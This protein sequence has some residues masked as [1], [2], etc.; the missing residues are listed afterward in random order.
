[1]NHKFTVVIPTR[2]RASTLRS[3]IESVIAQ[4]YDNLVI[5]VSDNAS[6]DHTQEVIRGFSDPRLQYVNPRR[7]LSMA[8]HFEFA[9]SHVVDG[10]VTSIGDD[11]A[12][13]LD[14]VAT[15]NDLLGSKNERALTSVYAQYDWPGMSN[16]RDNQLLFQTGTGVECRATKRFLDGVLNGSVSYREIPIAYGGFVKASELA[17]LR[18]RQ[19]RIF[20]S[21]QLDMYSAISLSHQIPTYLHSNRPLFINGTSTRSNGASHFCQT[22]DQTEKL[23]WEK[24]NDLQ[25]LAPFEVLPSIK[26]LLAE[27]YLQFKRSAPGC[28]VVNVDLGGMLRQAYCE[29][30]NTGNVAVADKIAN[31]SGQLGYALHRNSL[32]VI[33][34]RSGLRTR[35]LLHY[36]RSLTYK[37][38][39]LIDCGKFGISDVAG[40][41]RLMHYHQVQK[42]EDRLLTRIALWQRRFDRKRLT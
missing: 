6:A 18:A 41:A 22:K 26:L 7:R 15:A 24:E 31:I 1:M 21:N 30:L 13:A 33:S 2:E 19:G 36:V 32:G 27:A 10:Y 9:L 42:Q 3:T 35:R 29:Q 37:P 23:Q 8:A 39:A 34:T 28:E 16:G 11:D 25:M 40:A 4:N 14:A 38:S 12:L 17:A 5:L 20:L